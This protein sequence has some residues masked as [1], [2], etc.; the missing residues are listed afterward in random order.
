VFVPLVG[1]LASKGE[2]QELKVLQTG[3]ISRTIILSRRKIIGCALLISACFS[4]RFVLAEQQPQKCPPT[5]DSKN[6]STLRVFTRLVQVNVIVNDKHGNPIPGLTQKDFSVFDNG[7]PQEVRVF[8]SATDLPSGSSPVPLPPG[9]YTNRPEEQT[10]VPASITVILL[11]AL[12]TE[13]SDQTLARRQIIRVLKDIQPQEYVALYWLGNGLHI[14]HDFTTEASV[15]RRVLANYESKSSRELDNSELADPS[16]NTTN[17]STPAGQTFERQ[18]F[19]M[20]FDQRVANQSTRDR[21][22]ATV[23][24]LVAI[25]NHLG[26]R[27]GRKNLVWV[28]AS[29]PINLGR[30]KFDLNWTSDTGEE[31]AGDVARATRALTDADIAVYP[32]DA[33]GLVGSDL[34]ASGDDLGDH[35]PDPADADTHIPTRA[36]PETFDTMNVLAERTGGKAFY[37]TNDI[38]G[39][40]RHAMNDAR[41]TYT[42][43]YYP[44]AAKWDGSFREIKVKVAAPGAEVRAR[45]G[46]FALAD[47]PVPQVKNDRGLISQLAAS[48]LPATGIGLHASVRGSSSRDSGSKDSRSPIL[49]AEVHLDLHEVQMQQKD[50]RW[51]GTVQSVFLQLDNA[52]HV[53]HADDRTFYPDFDATT[54]ERVLRSGINDTR[55]VRVLSNAAELCIVVRDATNGNLGSI[56]VPLAQY[57]PVPSGTKQTKK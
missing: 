47:P 57:P 52:G 1:I 13:G 23:A 8:S 12:N 39:A 46:Y 54:F 36:A 51:S 44:A 24:A 37:G 2:R 16:L 17:P 3:V 6:L 41:V 53:L 30:D 45:T 38:S 11:D 34:T 25:A 14:L 33:R 48:R 19:R 35:V 42:L 28:S 4:A 22:H 55:Q 29:F 7:K 18:A 27:K 49:T 43:G 9:T 20:A 32:V 10:N 26:T 5:E 31:F 40:I 56:Y 15:L 50:G 21:V